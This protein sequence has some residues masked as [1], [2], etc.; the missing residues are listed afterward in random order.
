VNKVKLSVKW[1]KGWVLGTS[2]EQTGNEIKS[3][4]ENSV[5]GKQRGDQTGFL[6]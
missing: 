4:V 3:H 1:P 2:F 5:K 6:T